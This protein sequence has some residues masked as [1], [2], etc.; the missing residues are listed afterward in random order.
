MTK[1]GDCDSG[2]MFGWWRTK[3]GMVM[4]VI[5]V[6]VM[7]MVVLVVVV[8]RSSRVGDNIHDNNGGCGGVGRD[9]EESR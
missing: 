8:V 2:V 4:M 5:K 7:V 6:A 9:E 3:D 1:G